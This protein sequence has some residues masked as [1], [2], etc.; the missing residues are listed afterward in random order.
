MELAFNKRTALAIMRALRAKHGRERI[1]MR[2]TDAK[3]PDIYPM[4]R[5]TEGCLKRVNT[6]MGLPCNLADQIL[7]IAVPHR[8]GRIRSKAVACT[9]YANSAPPDAFV[10]IGNGASISSPE[11]LFVE[12]A[13]SMH[14]LEHLMLGHEL[15]GT[16]SR[17][18]ADPCNGP[19]TYDA[20][21][22]TSVQRITRFLETAH[23]TH[24]SEQ[25]R[26]PVVS[27]RQRLV[28]DRIPY[29]RPF[30]AAHRQLGL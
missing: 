21:P 18:D 23:Y 13:E 27:E 9:V 6:E 4:R 17:N 26:E 12:M 28:A 29:L 7:D 11:L 3:S 14:P 2:R 22:L 25:A 10:D 1:P 15:C 16:F 24:G 30:A 19:I 20:P 5:W 8:N